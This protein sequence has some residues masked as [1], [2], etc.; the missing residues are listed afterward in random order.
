MKALSYK[1]YSARIEFDG[2][3]EIFVGRIAGMT[4]D[5]RAETSGSG[6]EVSLVALPR[7]ASCGRARPVDRAGIGAIGP[8]SC[9]SG[10]ETGG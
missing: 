10:P 2:D 4:V 8:D 5:A 7:C 1:G 6:I 3:D 9:G